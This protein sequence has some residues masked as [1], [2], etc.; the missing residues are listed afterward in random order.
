VGHIVKLVP[1]HPTISAVNSG[2][3]LKVVPG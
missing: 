3:Y 1:M 2:V